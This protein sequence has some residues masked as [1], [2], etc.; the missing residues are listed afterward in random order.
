MNANL[1]DRILKYYRYMWVRTK[2]I[3]PETL[4]DGLTLS[5]QADVSMALYKEI[6]E[7]VS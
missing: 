3:D 6:I 4:F 2:G 1:K 7:K 5:L